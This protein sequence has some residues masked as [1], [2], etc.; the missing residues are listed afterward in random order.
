MIAFPF[1][2]FSSLPADVIY[3]YAH[4][5]RKNIAIG[6]AKNTATLKSLFPTYGMYFEKSPPETILPHHST[7]PINIS[8]IAPYVIRCFASFC[9]SSSPADIISLNIPQVIVSIAAPNINTRKNAIRFQKITRI[10]KHPKIQ[11]LQ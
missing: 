1:L 4:H 5:I 9:F 6:A 11:I 10:S 3:W 2:T 8:P 7:N